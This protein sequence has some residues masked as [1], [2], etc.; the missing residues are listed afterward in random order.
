MDESQPAIPDPDWLA[1]HLHIWNATE[2]GKTT[3]ALQA[4]IRRLLTRDGGR[5]LIFDCKGNIDL[6]VS[7]RDAAKRA[8]QERKWFK[9]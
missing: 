1:K 8:G 2:N 6:F 5:L 7:V 3:S 4:I 9:N